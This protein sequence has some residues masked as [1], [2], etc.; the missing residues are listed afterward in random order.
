MRAKFVKRSI[1][2]LVAAISILVAAGPALATE[3]GLRRFVA[4]A[5]SSSQE[6]IHGVLVYPTQ[7]SPKRIPMGPFTPTVAINGK[8]DAIVKGL[9][10]LSHGNAGSELGHVSLAEALA[11]NGYLVAALKHPGDN[12]QDQ[13]LLGVPGGYYFSERP[14]QASRVIDA[15]LSDPE[16]IP[17]ISADTHGPRVGAV[18]HS[19]GGYT[20]L[21]LAGGNPD[22]NRLVNHCRTSSDDPIFC[23][24]GRKV[25]TSGTEKI[26]FEGLRDSRVRAVA[27]LAPAGVVFSA[28]SLAT[29]SIPATIYSADKDTFLVPRYHAEWVR[30]NVAKADYHAIQNAGHYAF[31]DTPSMP[32]PSPDGDVGANPEGF[33]RAAFLKQLATALNQFFDR[34]LQ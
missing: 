5:Q 12:W 15:I 30:Q 24:M 23:S 28:Q 26:S 7:D 25:T 9:I 27:A 3:A 13:S 16:W 34:A 8:P 33:D 6:Q 18:G 11:K 32:I 22:F 19:A 10:V 17:R 14:R 4:P 31:M 1:G 2:F 20:V 21:A 29:I